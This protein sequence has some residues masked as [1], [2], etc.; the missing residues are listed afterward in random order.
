[1]NRN[2]PMSFALA[3]V[4]AMAIGAGGC[5]VE[6]TA[7]A[8]SPRQEAIPSTSYSYT[9]TTSGPILTAP[10]ATGTLIALDDAQIVTALN[11]SDRADIAQ[12][13]FALKQS[14]DDR[15]QRLAR[16]MIADH[17]HS[18]YAQTAVANSLAL[19]DAG[20]SLS[21]ELGRDAEETMRTFGPLTG[22]AFNRSFVDAQ[23]SEHQ[24]MLDII[25]S[26]LLP[27]AKSASVKQL[28]QQTRAKIVEHVKLAKDLRLEI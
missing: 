14:N 28:L 25:D 13:R 6:E 5:T 7:P 27:Q 18:E 21:H 17:T 24:K 2:L 26:Q 22:A 4:A 3:A 15:V 19:T 23:V 10:P 20:S 16:A 1:M 11:A 9:R 8:Q 12:C